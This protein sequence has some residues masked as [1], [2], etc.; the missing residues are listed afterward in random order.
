MI[1]VGKESWVVPLGTS[2]ALPDMEFSNTYLAVGKPS[3]CYWL[4]DCANSPIPRLMR[5]D[6]DPLAIEGIF[7]TH[8]HPDHVYGLPAYLLGLRMLA[9]ARNWA[10]AQPILVCARAETLSDLKALDAIFRPQG[11]L[12]DLPLVYTEVPS[13]VGAS[14]AETEAFRI[15][16]APAAH[17]LPSMAVRFET[18]NAS[19][20]FVYSGDTEPTAAIEQLA[21]GA[22]LLVHE[23]TGGGKGHSSPAEAGTVAAL[24]EAER[25]LLIHLAGDPQ[26]RAEACTEARS[27]FGGPV[28]IAGA[29]HRYEW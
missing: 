23:A 16:A 8:F 22:T 2:S 26:L 11:W 24:A 6:I 13:E 19:G 20:A 29:F 21:R 25:L 28:E 18:V 15:S 9:E 7:V 17:T 10:W 4:I 12:A 3:G 14:V 27:T 5:A 1:T